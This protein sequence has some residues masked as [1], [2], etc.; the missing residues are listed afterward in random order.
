MEFLL[1]FE[2]LCL[3]C[4]HFTDATFMKVP[5]TAHKKIYWNLEG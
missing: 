2:Y 4:L 5:P 1:S 3:F